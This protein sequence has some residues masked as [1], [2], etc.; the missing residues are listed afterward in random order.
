[1]T[2]KEKSLEK[3]INNPESIDMDKIAENPQIANDEEIYLILNTSLMILLDQHINLS[4]FSKLKYKL[5]KNEIKQ[6]AR[7]IFKEILNELIRRDDIRITP[8]LPLDNESNELDLPISQNSGIMYQGEIDTSKL[9]STDIGAFNNSHKDITNISDNDFNNNSSEIDSSGIDSS[10]INFDESE[11]E[12]VEIDLN[13]LNKLDD[14]TKSH[15]DIIFNNS[16]LEMTLLFF[17]QEQY[18]MAHFFINLYLKNR[19]TEN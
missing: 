4:F 9:K 13:N 11:P 18:E 7:I 17:D 12:V 16:A 6:S 5:V 1:M 10:E 19:I 3:L 15:M 14:E 8:I 2:I